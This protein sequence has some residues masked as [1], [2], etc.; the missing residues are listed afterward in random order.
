MRM[1]WGRLARYL[2]AGLLFLLLLACLYLWIQPP[3][4]PRP[5]NV[6]ADATLLPDGKGANIWQYCTMDSRRTVHCRIFNANGL[7]LYDDVFVV[8]SGSVPQTPDDL[9]ISLEGGGQ[10]ISLENG[11]ILIPRSQSAEMTRFLDWLF[12]KRETR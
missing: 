7:I 6:P 1:S 5:V 3:D 10:W 12:G 8:Y 11:T 2:G 9:K 4:K